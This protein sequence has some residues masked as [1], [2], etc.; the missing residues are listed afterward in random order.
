MGEKLRRS[1]R[2]LPSTAM[3]S[4]LDHL[5]PLFVK[6]RTNYYKIFSKK[7]PI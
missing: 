6:K 2:A 7:S 4:D 5:S 1:Y 3:K